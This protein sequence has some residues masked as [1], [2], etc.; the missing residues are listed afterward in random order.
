MFPIYYALLV[1]IEQS[2]WC[3]WQS[4]LDFLFTATT[5]DVVKALEGGA[6][7]ETSHSD[8]SESETWLDKISFTPK[9][10][11]VNGQILWLT[12]I[13]KIR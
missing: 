7:T 3:V 10:G 2:P 9:L 1:E 6:Q 13:N 11:V 12:L 8:E 5:G 4:K